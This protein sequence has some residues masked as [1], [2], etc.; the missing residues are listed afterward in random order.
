METPYA[1]LFLWMKKLVEITP[2]IIGKSF[3]R[4]MHNN[5]LWLGMEMMPSTLLMTVCAAKAQKQIIYMQN[6]VTV[7]VIFSIAA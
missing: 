3:M 6:Y 7:A 1:Y 4:I 5:L 2:Q